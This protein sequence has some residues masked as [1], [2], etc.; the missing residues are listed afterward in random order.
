MF[1]LVNVTRSVFEKYSFFVLESKVTAVVGALLIFLMV[2]SVR[3]KWFGSQRL[4]INTL[5]F[6]GVFM[7]W[8]TS[9]SIIFGLI[10]KATQHP[11]SATYEAKVKVTNILPPDMHNEQVVDVKAK[12]GDERRIDV[13]KDDVLNVKKGDIITLQVKYD[14]STI[15]LTKKT[16]GQPIPAIPLSELKDTY[17]E[18]DIK[19]IDK[20]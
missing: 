13:D 2:L 18:S 6:I 11:A 9:F 16:N 17:G 10:F 8:F 4:M 19:I 14:M 7:C 5:L 12:N 3:F 15:E 1:E 20:E